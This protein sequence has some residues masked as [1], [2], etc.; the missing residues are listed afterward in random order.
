MNGYENFKESLRSWLSAL[1]TIVF[2]GDRVG[3]KVGDKYLTVSI[4]LLY[5]EY[6]RSSMKDTIRFFLDEL[7]PERDAVEVVPCEQFVGEPDVLVA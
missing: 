5:R 3:K 4:R 7:D 1:P 6:S 2:Y